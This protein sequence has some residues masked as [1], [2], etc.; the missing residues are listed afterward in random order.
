MDQ[1]LI[2]VYFM[3]GMAASPKIF[4]YIKLPKDQFK[5]HF[6]EWIVP[7]E[8]ES[9]SAYAIRMSKHVKYE[10]VVLLGVSFGGV[11]VQEMSKYIKVRKLII[12]SSI[13]SMHEMPKRMLLAKSTSAYKIV[14]TPLAS[15]I[16]ILEKYAFGKQMTKRIELYKKYLSV[17]NSKYLSWAIKEMVCWNQK[18]PHP[19]IVHIH[20]DNDSVFPIKNIS[21]CI[22]IP[23][24]SHIMIIN[25]YKWFN[26]NLPGIILAD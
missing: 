23:N 3:P 9:L 18:L 8:N 20:G 19:K 26:T 22:I 25:K 11:L 12:V 1:E 2:H 15:K 14:P 7:L 5:A 24:G 13:K 10:N 21:N 17:N 16:D 4:E 6:L